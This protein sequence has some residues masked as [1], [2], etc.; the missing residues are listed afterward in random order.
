MDYTN[1]KRAFQEAKRVIPGGVNSPAR[2]M[3]SVGCDPLFIQKAKGAFI[4]DIDGN[5]FVDFIG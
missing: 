3:E 4:Y 1:S 2:A 5:D